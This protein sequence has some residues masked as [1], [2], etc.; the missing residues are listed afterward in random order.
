[1][2]I[3]GN[4]VCPSCG[5]RFET[6]PAIVDFGQAAGPFNFP[7]IPPRVRCPRCR[8][9]FRSSGIRYFGILKPRTFG[10]L[11]AIY[12]FA[13]LLFGAFAFLH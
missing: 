2:N 4:E 13:F 12:V 3:P 11:L 9:Q 5:L 8:H 7:A 1:M 6:R 10:V